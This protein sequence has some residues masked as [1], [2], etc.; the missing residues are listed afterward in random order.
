MRTEDFD[1]ELPPG[2]V[3]THPLPERAAS[4]MMVISRE[5]GTI[6]HRKFAE[7][8]SFVR[9]DDLFVFN[10]TRVVPARFFSDD[11]RIELL[12]VDNADP[13]HWRCLVRPG[14]R[15]KVGRSVEIGGSTGT[16]T[17]IDEL[18][19]RLITW[20][21]PVDED[22]HGEL[23]IPPY[24]ERGEEASDAERYQT[25]YARQDG[26]VAAPTAGLHFTPDLIASLPHAFLTLHVG[27]GTFRPVQVDN[28]AEHRM[29]D[30]AYELGAASAE[31]ITRAG[32]VISVG[33]TVTR[34]LEHLGRRGPVT[35]G[36]GRTDIFIYPPYKF[37]VVDGLLTNFHLPKSTLL[38]LVSAFAN[39]DLVMEA[40]E[41]AVRERYRFY[42]YGD[43][44]LIL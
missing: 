27:P 30:E 40:Y 24:M 12:R 23:A 43:C 22:A 25:V 9:D 17:G 32:R 4:R 41:Q 6:E 13:L 39:R 26:A 29:H 8:P 28:P 42:S 7:L 11:R 14:K 16:V 18:G 35:A 15:M 10:D 5:Q 34:V 21:Q 44:M 36:Q 2:L 31:R 19:Y 20:D 37:Q 3:A 33:T 38:M 1:Y